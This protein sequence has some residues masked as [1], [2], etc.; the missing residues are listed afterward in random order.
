MYVLMV[1]PGQPPEAKEIKDGLASLQA[2]VGGP[3]QA[4]YPFAEPVALICHE[5]GKLLG[6]SLNRCLS[7]EDTG[8]I[9]DI[10]AGTFLLCAAPPTVTALR[11][12]LRNRRSAMQGASSIR[13]T[14]RCAML[15]RLFVEHARYGEPEYSRKSAEINRAIKTL[16]ETLEPAEIQLLAQ[17]EDTYQAREAA[18][19]RSAFEEGF[20]SAVGLALD[21]LERWPLRGRG[22]A[23]SHP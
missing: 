14:S 13:G 10:I 18:A 22:A 4:L 7:L 6:L 15:E 2:E 5:E 9:Y 17:L 19:V 1:Q 8:E 21:I 23:A 11:A 16:S 20:C 3:I 12:L